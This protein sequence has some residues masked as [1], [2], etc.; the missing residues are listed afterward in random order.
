MKKNFCRSILIVALL[1]VFVL[2]F[3]TACSS[4]NSGSK[5]AIEA[6]GDEDSGSYSA[7]N[8]SYSSYGESVKDSDNETASSDKSEKGTNQLDEKLV[9]IA[10]LDLQT[11]EYSDTISKI[12]GY[13]DS[14]DCI[15]ESQNERDSDYLTYGDYIYDE[16]DKTSSSEGS[17]SCH[18]CIRVP[19]DKFF[20]FVSDISEIAHVTSKEIDVQNISDVYNSNDATIKALERQQERL[21]EM[22]DNTDSIDA[23]LSITN[24]LSEVE[25]QLNTDKTNKA[26][27]DKS[28]AYSTVKLYVD[29]VVKYTE[30]KKP[31]FWQELGENFSAAW[32][33]FLAILKGLLF[34]FI[35]ALPY[36]LIIAVITFVIVKAILLSVRKKHKKVVEHVTQSS[37]TDESVDIPD[38]EEKQNVSD[39]D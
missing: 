10:N 27:M 5:N 22:L 20:S 8:D 2:S 1:S 14:Y 24:Q 23:M 9:Y 35:R 32:G 18:Y 21:L 30:T 13:I 33:D 6:L 16:Y 11:L 28:I 4:G 39:V 19:S 31:T 29:E 36:M 34:F 15:L 37:N 3:L 7:N 26:T 25:R 12:Q 17:L 38:I